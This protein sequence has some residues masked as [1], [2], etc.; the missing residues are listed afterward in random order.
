[1]PKIADVRQHIQDTTACSR[2]EA[3]AAAN[4]CFSAPDWALAVLGIEAYHHMF[5]DPTGEQA[6]NNAMK[7]PA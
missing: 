2:R 3:T 6:V 5:G 7:E 4:K 1:M